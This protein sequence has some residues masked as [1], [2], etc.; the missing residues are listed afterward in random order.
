MFFLLRKL[1]PKLTE[2]DIFQLIKTSTD[3]FYLLQVPS[4][5]SAV[6]EKTKDSKASTPKP[7]DS[8]TNNE[9]STDE[10]NILHGNNLYEL[11]AK[12]LDDLLK[13]ILERDVNNEGLTSIYKH[14]EPW[15]TSVNDHE[16]LRS[17]RSLCSILKH[18]ANIYKPNEDEKKP[19]SLESFGTILGRIVSRSTDPVIQIRTYTV[20]CIENLIKINN[21]MKND[22]KQTDD[23]EIES[24]SSI[25]QK[26]V[27][28]DSNILLSAV[29]DLS[30]ILCKQVTSGDQL[31][32]FIEKLIDGLLDIQSHCS[33]ASCIFLNYCVKIRAGEL[34]AQVDNLIRHLYTK[35]GLIQN[36]Q[37]K[38]GTLRTIRVLFQQHLIESLN[39]L[40]S[41]PIPCNK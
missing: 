24:L 7:N 1:N 9:E 11:T 37:A 39:V 25:K 27:K 13:T 8:I 36:Q 41:L 3:S 12:C 2:A 6:E 14:L 35:L 30:K 28:N 10:N 20:D 33:S 15:L 23:K 4:S 5:P 18:F 29:S 40:L 19:S 32:I 17:I 26:L 38:L 34:K 31:I 22:E 16:R 21:L